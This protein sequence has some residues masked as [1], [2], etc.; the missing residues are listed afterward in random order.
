MEKRKRGRPRI[1]PRGRIFTLYVSQED[2]EK[3]EQITAQSGMTISEF[4]RNCVAEKLKEYKKEYK[5]S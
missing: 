1:I 4:I 2:I 3:I 5:F